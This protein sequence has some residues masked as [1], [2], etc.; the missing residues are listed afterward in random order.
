MTQSLVVMRSV[1]ILYP[2]TSCISVYGFEW[3]AAD[4]YEEHPDCQMVQE[5]GSWLVMTAQVTA[6]TE[7]LLYTC[8]YDLQLNKQMRP[9]VKSDVVSALP[10][11]RVW[12]ASN[13]PCNLGHLYFACFILI[14]LPSKPP[15]LCCCCCCTFLNLSCSCWP[16][17]P[18]WCMS[19][20]SGLSKSYT[21]KSQSRKTNRMPNVFICSS[22][23]SAE[24]YSC[25]GQD[26]KSS[27][28]MW[29]WQI[30]GKYTAV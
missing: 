9:V 1:G 6:E 3:N 25:V 21:Q 26:S 8:W 14:T 30:H 27:E 13:L 2:C 22:L 20:L 7:N 5:Q 28:T 19:T 29:H 11:S 12:S 24:V 10:Y 16:S 23:D 4:R 18:G 17:L 15:P